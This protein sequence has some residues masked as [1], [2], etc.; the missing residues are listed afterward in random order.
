VIVAEANRATGWDAERTRSWLS[1]LADY[2]TPLVPVSAA[3]F[4]AASLRTGEHV[5]DV[6]CGAGATTVEAARLVGPAG[7]VVGL[8][9]SPEMIDAA[10]RR[11]EA[12]NIEWLVADAGENDLPPRAFDAIISRFGLMFFP[13]PEVAFRRL[14][15]ACQLGGRLVASV[16]VQRAEV[17]Y[18]AVP[19]E[20][21][22]SLLDKHGAR[23]TPVSGVD[24]P[25]SLGNSE[26]TAELFRRAGWAE[27]DCKL[28]SDPLYLGGPG[29]VQHAADALVRL[30][31]LLTGQPEELITEARA[32]LAE[33]LQR[34]HDGT[35]VA[36]PSGFLLITA[37][38][39]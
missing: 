24:G 30:S 38:R 6:G 33:R 14:H 16:W 18:L 8:D 35:G 7:R 20:I 21:L 3:I 22:T 19:Y 27:I 29:T 2:E 37:K 32:T 28:R 25:F 13:D 34:W 31:S 9:I 15:T 10:R 1:N 12:V 17:P 5:L 11:S 4:D 23:Y 26:Q 39:F 36:L